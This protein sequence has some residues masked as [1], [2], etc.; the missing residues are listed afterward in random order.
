[1]SS[2]RYTTVRALIM[3]VLTSL[4][5]IVSAPAA[6]A[7]GGPDIVIKPIVGPR[8]SPAPIP[9][10]SVIPGGT[11]QA[12]AISP[13][14]TFA[15]EAAT[16][17]G[18]VGK[19]GVLQTATGVGSGLTLYEPEEVC[20]NFNAAGRWDG[21]TWTN[22][23]AGW[24]TY[25][26]DG[27]IYQAKNVTFDRERAVGPGN[28]YSSGQSSMKIASNQPYEAGIMSPAINVDSGDVVRVRAAYLIFNHDT[29]GRNWDY[30]SMG[31]IPNIGE[32]ATY[33]QGYQRGEWAIL[34]Q[35]IVATGEQV[36]VMLQGHSPDA[37]NSNVYFDNVEIYV[38]GS[39]RSNCRG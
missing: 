2:L 7:Q 4:L 5:I 21:E 13:Q 22:Y 9:H 19:P 32:T 15:N 34:D 24:G 33:V 6:L 20:N 17:Q 36:V 38:N 35:E 26:A 31:I 12:Q 18:T 37:I 28:R 23:F 16:R 1:M 8:R 3:L 14:S 27:G 30:V 29:K 11:I 25:A 39:P 10:T